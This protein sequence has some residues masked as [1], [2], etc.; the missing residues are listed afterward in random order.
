MRRP[1]PHGPL[2]PTAL[3]LLGFC[4]PPTHLTAVGE[5]APWLLLLETKMVVSMDMWKLRSTPSP[6]RSTCAC[7]EGVGRGKGQGQEEGLYNR[8][9]TKASAMGVINMSNDTPRPPRTRWGG[10]KHT[11]PAKLLP[12]LRMATRVSHL[13]R[14]RHLRRKGEQHGNGQGAQTSGQRVRTHAT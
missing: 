2:V 5:H 10:A 4:L 14:R 9:P 7:R 6:R 11:H 3:F 1:L 12:F 13:A 8:G